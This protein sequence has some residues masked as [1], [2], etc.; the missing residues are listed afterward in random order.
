MIFRCLNMGSRLR[1]L[2]VSHVHQAFVEAQKHGGAILAFSDHDYRDIR[3]DIEAV[4]VMIAEVRPK[5]SDVSIRFSGA[6]EA[7]RDLLGVGAE[8][9]PELSLRLDG[10]RLVIKTEKGDIFGPQPFL[11]LKSRGGRVF[12][13]NLDV[14]VPGR[15][16]TY[17]LDDQTLPPSALALAGVGTAGRHGGFHVV[18]LEINP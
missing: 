5:F 2:N 8:S 12:H 7:V 3:P 4:R 10:N 1:M 18:R 6:E 14:Q 11:A 9:S 13:D 15:L 16:W 17:T